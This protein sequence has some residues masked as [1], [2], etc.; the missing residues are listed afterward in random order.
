[1]EIEIPRKW[2]HLWLYM[3]LLFGPAFLGSAISPMTGQER[4]LLLTPRLARLNAYRIKAQGWI[5]EFKK[6]DDDL[7]VLLDDPTKD[8]FSQNEHISRLYQRIL[9]V[10]D[11]IDQTSIPP[12][13]ETLHT[14]LA[15][16]AQAY[17]NATI[18]AARWIS[19]PSVENHQTTL[20]AR[21]S[22]QIMLEHLEDNPWIEVYP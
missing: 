10:S 11:T 16:T 18:L 6:A 19:E 1:M 12:T 17:L 14:Q 3:L 13:M 4:P 9:T 20:S 15:E 7:T 22:S 21:T 8:L 5:L 2:L